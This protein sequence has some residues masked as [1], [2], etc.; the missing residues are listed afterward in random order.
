MLTENLFQ[1]SNG[2]MHAILCTKSGA[3][4]FFSIKRGKGEEKRG[5]VQSSSITMTEPL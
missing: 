3:K 5:K 2:E 1:K 4:I